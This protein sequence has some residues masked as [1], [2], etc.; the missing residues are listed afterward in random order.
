[1]TDMTQDLISPEVEAAAD[2]ARVTVGIYTDD[3]PSSPREWSNIGKLYMFNN[4]NFE[5]GD[6]RLSDRETFLDN[7]PDPRTYF[8][9]ELDCKRTDIIIHDIQVVFHGNSSPS[10][11]RMMAHDRE[12][13]RD[14]YYVTTK[15]FIREDQ[16]VKAISK[17]IMAKVERLMRGEIDTYTQYING[18]VYGYTITCDLTGETVDSVWGFY[19]DDDKYL[20]EAI[21]DAIDAWTPPVIYTFKFKP[22]LMAWSKK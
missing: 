19:G 21:K 22:N 11:L 2:K 6:E 13:P 8:A 14:G 20:N 15:Q 1:M 5:L 18:E 3:T 4:R 7:Y 16:Q 10:D 9:E 17:A 12:H